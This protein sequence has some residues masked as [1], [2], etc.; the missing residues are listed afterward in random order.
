MKK[1]TLKEILLIALA[2][3]LFYPFFF[4]GGI[5]AI[6]LFGEGSSLTDKKIVICTIASL[7]LLSIVFARLYRPNGVFKKWWSPVL[8]LLLIW[9]QFFLMSGKIQL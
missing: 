2:A 1:S 8:C 9:G 4:L 6:L 5:A 7:A 3:V